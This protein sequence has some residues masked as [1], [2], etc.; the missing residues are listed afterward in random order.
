MHAQTT[1][2]GEVRPPFF[3]L[4][5]KYLIE[6]GA[7]PDELVNDFECLFSCAM[8]VLD[9]EGSE[10]LDEAQWGGLYLLRQSHAVF[11]ELRR[12]LGAQGL[13]DVIPEAL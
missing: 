13:V 2:G 9:H 4:D 6:Q 3:E 8:A 5:A 11:K 10:K 12:K 1:P 7:T